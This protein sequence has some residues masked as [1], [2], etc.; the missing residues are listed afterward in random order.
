MA[1]LKGILVFLVLLCCQYGA[2]YRVYILPEPRLS[3]FCLSIFSG[4]DCIT[5]S[6]YSANPKLA[7]HSTTLIFTPGVYRYS[8][9]YRRT[10]QLSVT[11]VKR[12]TMIGDTG[13]ELQFWLWFSNIGQVYMQNLM[14]SNS[15]RINVRNVQSFMMENCTLLPAL[16]T[17]SSPG[18]CISNSKLV[19]VI[20]STL[21]KVKIDVQSHSMLFTDRC[22][23][24]SSSTATVISG[25]SYSTL[26]L[27]NSNFLNN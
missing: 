9:S 22:T 14:L 26:I 5:W 3:A 18:M 12:F 19:Q 10:L 17:S 21:N 15:P 13:A 1:A 6:D 7:D 27:N 16:Q 8:R 24:I 23:F 25:D 20:E 11:N 4:D 2:S